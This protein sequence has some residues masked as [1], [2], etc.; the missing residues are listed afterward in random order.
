MGLEAWL[1]LFNT[2]ILTVLIPNS[3][4]LDHHIIYNQP[5]NLNVT[6][7]LLKNIEII[8]SFHTSSSLNTHVS[9]QNL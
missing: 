8:F 3:P 7:W 6:V 5:V 2:L 4:N 1:S 9:P